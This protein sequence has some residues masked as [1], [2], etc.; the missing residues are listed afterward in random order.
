M[1]DYNFEPDYKSWWKKKSATKEDWALLLLG[2]EP[3]TIKKAGEIQKKA[4]RSDEDRLF[5]DSLDFFL[6]R[7]PG[8]SFWKIHYKALLNLDWGGGKENFIKSAYE[9]AHEIPDG[10]CQYLTS[11]GKMPNNPNLEEFKDYKQYREDLG[12]WKLG[13]VPNNFT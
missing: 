13:S 5:L 4:M 7:I 8:G 9:N 1:I 11:I 2:I 12:E 10:L 6:S 3:E